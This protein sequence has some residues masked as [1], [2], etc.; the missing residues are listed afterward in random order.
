M[1]HSLI[2]QRRKEKEMR[3]NLRR[4]TTVFFTIALFIVVPGLTPINAAEKYPSKPIT[5]ILPWAGGGLK[6]VLLRTLQPILEKELGVPIVIVEK[7]GSGG[8]V[9]WA[10]LQAEKPDGYTIAP[11]SNSIFGAHWVTK[12]R[13]DYRNFEPFASLTQDYFSITVNSESPWKTF[14]EF[15]K[16]VKANPEKVRAGSSGTGGIWHLCLMAFNKAAGT[17]IVHVP[18]EGGGKAVVAVMGKHIESTIVT[19]GDMTATLPTGKLRILALGGPARNPFYPDVP[20]VKE[21]GIDLVMGNW[22]GMVA[23]KGTPKER[24]QVLEKAFANAAQNPQ[25]IEFLKKNRVTNDFAGTE[26]TRK[27]YFQTA[28]T[29]LAFLKTL[30]KKPR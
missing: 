29:M 25:Y 11:G 15:Y 28:E 4:L 26:E 24:I 13:V 12:G 21:L 30:E 16:Y 10:T 20:T 8:A 2:N 9:G 22:S 3:W 27:Y 7:P 14:D 5:I 17:K 6:N 23:P 19:P 18:F 1:V